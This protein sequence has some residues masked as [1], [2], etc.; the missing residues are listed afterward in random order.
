V[1]TRRT[2]DAVDRVVGIEAGMSDPANHGVLWKGYAYDTIGNVKVRGDGVANTNEVFDY[3]T[4]NRLPS[5]SASGAGVTSK[6]V[7]YLP[8]GNINWKSD[9]G[10]YTYGGPRPYALTQAGGFTLSGY[11]ANGNLTQ[12]TAPDGLTR[13]DTYTSYNM[14]STMSMSNGNSL[15]Y[16]YNGEHQ[17]IREIRT[18]NG[19]TTT[20]YSMHPD[21]QG[22]LL[23][24]KEIVNG[25]AKHKHYINGGS[26]VAAVVIAETA[27]YTEY[28]HK[29]ALGSVVAVS[30][31]GS[32]L[33]L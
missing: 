26:G 9:V 13:T 30:V 32:G 11:D 15:N 4:L 22:G 10:Q 17:R 20:L 5:V 21:N 24:E 27:W 12:Y 8:N 3:D 6:S 18:I 31:K 25:Q 23:Y 33:S 28:W 1:V 2:Y 29:D 16:L 19:V 14:L 7:N